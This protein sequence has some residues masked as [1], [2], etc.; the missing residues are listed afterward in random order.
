MSRQKRLEAHALRRLERPE[1]STSPEVTKG[2]GPALGTMAQHI[3]RGRLAS[4]ARAPPHAFL[5]LTD[6][7]PQ[8]P[9]TTA[10]VLQGASLSQGVWQIYCRVPWHL[11]R[12]HCR[13]VLLRHGAA[14]AGTVAGAPWLAH[15]QSAR[16]AS[17]RSS[18]QAVAGSPGHRLDRGPPPDPG[19]PGLTSRLPE[20]PLDRHRACKATRSTSWG[21]SRGLDMRAPVPSACMQQS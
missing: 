5:C 9:W 6:R 15:E 17:L 16:S 14:L 20:S 2:V 7:I 21:G 8:S 13:V 10:I 19:P 1:V 18:A 4:T 12:G 11:H 3:R